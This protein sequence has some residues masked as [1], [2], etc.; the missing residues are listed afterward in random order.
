MLEGLSVH[1]G[2]GIVGKEDEIHQQNSV[3]NCDSARIGLGYNGW[4]KWKTTPVSCELCFLKEGLSFLLF[5]C[6]GE[7][8]E[9]A[10]AAWTM[11]AKGSHHA[12][13]RAA[14]RAAGRD[15]LRTG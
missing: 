4:N 9:A 13:A 2:M 1:R 15:R 7:D 14:V 8:A 3:E 11:G 6:L 10:A 12:R 5:L